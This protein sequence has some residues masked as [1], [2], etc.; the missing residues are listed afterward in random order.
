[1]LAKSFARQLKNPTYLRRL[2]SKEVT[3]SSDSAP[4][5]FESIQFSKHKL[6]NFGELPKGE[7]PFALQYSPENFQ[8]QLSNR[9]QVF[10]EKYAGDFATVSF[11]IKAGSRYE[12]IEN[13]GASHFLTYQISKGSR[14]LNKADFQK[15][16]DK[17]GG[18]I[19]VTLGRE[20]IGFTNNF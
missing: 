4:A 12:T 11:F 1:M 3:K 15:A 13:S 10:T 6:T 16:L 20:I 9:I 7:V 18:Q 2:F 17:T 19:E 14:N 8:V 5:F